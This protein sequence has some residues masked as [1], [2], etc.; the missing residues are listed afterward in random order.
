MDS[1]VLVLVVA[2]GVL[3]T[4]L[5]GVAVT[6][7]L[8]LRAPSS[9][10]RRLEAPQRSEDWTAD[11]EADGLM[12]RAIER[13]EQEAVRARKL[14]ALYGTLDLDELLLRVLETAVG[15]TGADAAAVA[16]EQAT[17]PPLETRFGLA[18]HESAPSLDALNGESRARA[19]T[20]DYRY[21]SAQN[22]GGGDE[23]LRRGVVVPIPS[24][25][26]EIPLGTLAVYWRREVDDL[27][28]DELAGLEELARSSARAIENARR[29]KA[30]HDLAELDPLS[31]LY[32]R[33]YFQDTLSREVKR[34]QRYRRRLA[35]LVFDVDGLKAINDEH[36]HL[37]GDSLLLETADRLRSVTRS[38]DVACRVGGDEFAVILPE[39]AVADAKQLHERLTRVLRAEA[40]G[41]VDRIEI[42]AG[43]A[44]LRPDERSVEFFD[45]ADQALLSAKRSGRGR[46]ALADEPEVN[47][48]NAD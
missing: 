13:A 6:T 19:V 18:A 45:R 17:G 30:V 36:G 43:I 26:E 14:A 11:V 20:L 23:P 41:T 2:A 22:T 16:L 31:G 39:S 21:G 47:K 1:T 42:S 8:R 33:R 44:Q 46:L 27:T 28:E 7:L 4:V 9:R 48:A 10:P 40:A 34:A 29:Y 35:L 24:T 32:N 5:L 15:V 25:T 12:R 37:A 38:A 3:A